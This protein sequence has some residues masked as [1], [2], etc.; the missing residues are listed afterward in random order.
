MN[1]WTHGVNGM[2]NCTLTHFN[3]YSYTHTHMHPHSHTHMHPHSHTHAPS[4][5]HT[6]I[7][8]HTHTRHRHPQPASSP[9]SPISHAPSFRCQQRSTHDTADVSE[10]SS[11]QLTH[12]PGKHV[13]IISGCCKHTFS[14]SCTCVIRILCIEFLNCCV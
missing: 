4:R 13:V 11:R 10:G 3:S 14:Q 5:T 6:F 2:L 7:H 9:S 12:Q 8:T 1:A